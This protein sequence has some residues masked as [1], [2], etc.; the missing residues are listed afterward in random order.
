MQVVRVIASPVLEAVSGVL[1]DGDD[2]GAALGHVDQVS[3]GPVREL[4]CVHDAG[5]PHD[6]AHVGYGRPLRHSIE[7]R[8]V[9]VREYKSHE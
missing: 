3:G 9:T 7:L 2:V 6:V 1:D 4:H 5:G 8:H